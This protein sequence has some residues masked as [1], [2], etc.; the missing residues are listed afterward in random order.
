MLAALEPSEGVG[1]DFSPALIEMATTRHP[2]MRFLRADAH[3]FNLSEKFDYIILSDLVNDLWDVQSVFDRMEQACVPD[4]RIV[5]NTYSRLWEIPLSVARGLRL[6]NPVLG[7]NWLTVDDLANLL[8]LSG[9]QVIRSW[10]EILCP[11]RVPPLDSICNKYLVKM[12]AIRHAR[13]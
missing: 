11:V 1:I 12:P 8:G 5:L 13:R 3:E 2:E 9:F 4:T 7:Q 6:A 10:Q